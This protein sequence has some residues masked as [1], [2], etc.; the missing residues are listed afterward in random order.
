MN[1]KAKKDALLNFVFKYSFQRGDFQLSSG[2]KS[3]FYIDIKQTTLDPRGSLLVAEILLDQLISSKVSSIGGL[4]IGADPIIGSVVTLSAQRGYPVAGFIVRKE[5]KRHGLH[6]LIEGKIAEGD[7]VIIIDDVITT[8]NSAYKAVQAVEELK[9]EVVK[10]IPVVDR[11][12]GGRAFF[13][14]KGY[15][16]HPILTIKEIFAL[17]SHFNPS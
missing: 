2:K 1:K 12:E 6:R 4:T 7:R 16:Y 10:I 9:C 5:P 8:G 11:D 17:A 14:D 3:D 15:D 13:E